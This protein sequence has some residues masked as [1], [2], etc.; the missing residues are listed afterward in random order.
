MRKLLGFIAV[1]GLIACGKSE[2]SNAPQAEAA[3]ITAPTAPEVAA[4]PLPAPNAAL[5][6]EL[7]IIYVGNM[8]GELEPCG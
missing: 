1:L 3:L 4:A 2:T 6:M 7:G 8:M 5:G